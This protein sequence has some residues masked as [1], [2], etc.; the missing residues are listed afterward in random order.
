MNQTQHLSLFTLQKRTKIMMD[1]IMH[2]A[3]IRRNGIQL[4]MNFHF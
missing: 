2:G 4:V 1:Y 3:Q